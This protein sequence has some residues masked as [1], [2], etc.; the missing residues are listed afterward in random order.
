MHEDLYSQL[1]Y[2]AIH[3]GIKITKVVGDENDPDVALC[4]KRII[5]INRN[6]ESNISSVI[7]LAH[8]IT[9]INHP[10]HSRLYM[11]STHIRNEEERITDEQAIR[12]V[13]KLFY[14]DTPNE[15]R[16]WVE[17]M[18]EFCLPSQ[19]APLVKDAIYD[20]DCTRPLQVNG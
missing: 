14:G 5:N 18:N 6:Y 9:H 12:I 17:F 3:D 1:L 11:F 19:F 20:C 10:H 16:N 13:A 8:E 2:I 15:C 4:K 7:R